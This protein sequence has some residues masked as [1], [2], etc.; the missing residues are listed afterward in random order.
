MGSSG[1]KSLVRQ[2]DKN[3]RSLKISPF[4][5]KGPMPEDLYPCPRCLLLLSARC[6]FGNPCCPKPHTFGFSSLGWAPQA[7][8]TFPQAPFYL[9]YFSFRFPRYRNKREDCNKIAPKMSMRTVCSILM[10]PHFHLCSKE[11]QLYIRE[12]FHN[13][14]YSC[15]LPWQIL[16]FFCNPS[17]LVPFASPDLITG[18]AFTAQD[19]LGISIT[20]RVFAPKS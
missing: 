11:S 3:M 20:R 9:H 2:L 12:T 15:C 17:S 16:N 8:R 4:M 19:R 1:G 6:Q 13:T 18:Y 14:N 5:P 10:S 7:V